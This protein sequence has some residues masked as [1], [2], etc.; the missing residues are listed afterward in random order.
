MQFNQFIELLVPQSSICSCPRQETASRN[1]RFNIGR[2]SLT[3][4]QETAMWL[5]GGDVP[6]AVLGQL[7][8]GVTGLGVDE[9][10]AL[11]KVLIH[12]PTM[13]EGMLERTVHHHFSVDGLQLSTMSM[14]EHFDMVKYAKK[15]VL[16]ELMQD[17]CQPFA[18]YHRPVATSSVMLG[19]LSCNL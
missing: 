14:A 7:F 19:R 12:N 16:D 5:G 15:Q 3:D 11:A 18:T 17:T 4:K 1:L 9:K 13:Y 2:Q 8:S 10:S 6:K